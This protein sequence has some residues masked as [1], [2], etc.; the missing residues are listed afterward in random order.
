MSKFGDERLFFAH[1]NTAGDRD[2]WPDGWGRADRNIDPRFD[3]DN[4]DNIWGNFVPAEDEGGWPSDPEGAQTMFMQQN[5]VHGCP[6]YW[7]L[8]SLS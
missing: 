4:A 2:F 5:E 1:M 3:N 8:E 6:F 7:L